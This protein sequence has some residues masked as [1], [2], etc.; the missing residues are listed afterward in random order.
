MESSV[1]IHSEVS[2]LIVIS[3]TFTLKNL[4]SVS[5]PKA[6]KKGKVGSKVENQLFLCFFLGLNQLN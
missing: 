1:H 5:L 2:A 6:N 4:K 3:F